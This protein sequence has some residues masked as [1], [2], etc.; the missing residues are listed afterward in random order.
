MRELVVSGGVSAEDSSFHSLPLL[1]AKLIAYK[2]TWM[3]V[4]RQ[5]FSHQGDDG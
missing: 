1:L 4:S 5:I 2:A 3:N